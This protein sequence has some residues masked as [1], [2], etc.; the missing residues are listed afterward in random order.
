MWKS[1]GWIEML[2]SCVRQHPTTKWKDAEVF[3]ILVNVINR[4]KCIAKKQKL[5]RRD[6][7]GYRKNS[8][9][10]TL[11]TGV[12]CD[13]SDRLDSNSDHVT[14]HE[15]HID[16]DQEELIDE[17]N[18]TCEEENDG[19]DGVDITSN[20]EPHDGKNNHNSVDT[21]SNNNE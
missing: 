13:N 7:F 21:R 19:I 12:M 3:K 16:N 15:I 14:Q 5:I 11:S 9:N 8:L 18:E 10:Y 2:Q 1:P 20:Q 4:I 17:D 6:K